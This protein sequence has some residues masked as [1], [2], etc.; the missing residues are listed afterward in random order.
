MGIIIIHPSHNFIITDFTEGVKGNLSKSKLVLYTRKAPCNPGSVSPEGDGGHSSRPAVAGRLQRPTRGGAS[1][2]TPDPGR[3]RRLFGL[4]SGG[5]C[6]AGA[7]ADAAVSSYLAFSP[8]PVP[9]RAIG[10]LFSVALS[11]RLTAPGCYPAP[12]PAK[13]GISSARLRGRG[14]PGT[15][16]DKYIS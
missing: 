16:R 15:S 8:L 7:V 4:A 6:L 12:C 11:R 13:P 5:V 3:S 2:R 9:V 10:G 1:S 14:R